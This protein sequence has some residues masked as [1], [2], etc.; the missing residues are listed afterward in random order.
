MKKEL[1]PAAMSFPTP[2]YIVATYNEDGSAD[3]MNLA[4]GGVCGAKPPCL[5]ISLN[6]GRRTRENILRTGAFTVNIGGAS[7]M[8]ESDYFGLVSGA[9]EDK[10][11]KTGITVTKSSHVPAPMLDAYPL[12]ISCKLRSTQEIGPHLM[13]IGEIVGIA[14]EESILDASG[15]ISIEKLSPLGLDPVGHHYLAFSEII[16]HAYQEGR[17]YLEK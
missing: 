16:G 17:E 4:W 12:S 3:A 5:Q 1:T 14:A 7:L 6:T 10:L 2:I 13:V 8:K 15:Q 11:K 9:Q